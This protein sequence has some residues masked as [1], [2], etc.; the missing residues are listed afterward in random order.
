VQFK[1]SD[2]A[3]P[4]HVARVFKD[5]QY[6]YVFNLCGE[7]RFGLS[8]K[9]STSDPSASAQCKERSASAVQPSRIPTLTVACYLLLHCFH[10][11]LG[12]SN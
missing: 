8:D 6:D 9:V 4:D 1:H 12:L 10:T 3:K 11:P 7:T 5:M 2:L